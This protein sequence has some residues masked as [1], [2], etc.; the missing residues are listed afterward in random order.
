[1]NSI[2]PA[3]EKFDFASH[4]GPWERSCRGTA[5]GRGAV[6]DMNV[7]ASP[8]V[9]PDP[10]RAIPTERIAMKKIAVLTGSCLLAAFVTLPAFAAPDAGVDAAVL[11]VGRTLADVGLT[12]F[13]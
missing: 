10:R 9:P 4:C 13:A 7:Q 8:L 11:L 12:N 5:A 6:M 1:M 3:T 2:H